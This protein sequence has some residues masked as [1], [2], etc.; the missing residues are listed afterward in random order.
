MAYFQNRL[1]RL[2]S[3]APGFSPVA[4]DVPTVSAASAAFPAA[5]KAVET[6]FA[7]AVRPSPG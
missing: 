7:S 5:G 2:L 1:N 6:A 3:L 4:H